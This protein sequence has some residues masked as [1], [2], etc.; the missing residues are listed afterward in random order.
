[1]TDTQ[2]ALFEIEPEAAPAAAVADELDWWGFILRSLPDCQCR[3]M[4]HEQACVADHN[5]LAG[6]RGCDC[7][8]TTLP[9]GAVELAFP[10]EF[11]DGCGVW[12]EIRSHYWGA[13]LSVE[14]EDRKVYAP[15]TEMR[16]ACSSSGYRSHI[17]AM[18]T[19]PGPGGWV[20]WG[21]AIAGEAHREWC[22]PKG[23]KR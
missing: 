7:A 18:N 1:M 15:H 12:V 23:K 4:G 3:A 22:C 21:F 6:C 20:G 13:T 9:P 2:L 17:G 14:G 8:A 19:D 10:V 11:A 16:G 5:Y